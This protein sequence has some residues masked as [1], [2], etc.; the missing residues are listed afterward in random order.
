[1]GLDLARFPHFSLIFFSFYH[2]AL[3]FTVFSSF[4]THLSD[5]YQR[6]HSVAV[7]SIRFVALQY[8]RGS[9]LVAERSWEQNPSQ[10]GVMASDVF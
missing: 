8:T 5:R 2:C 10:R 4:S 3:I 9:F 7:C 6:T 1:M